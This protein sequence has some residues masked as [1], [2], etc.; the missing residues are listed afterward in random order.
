MENLKKILKR[1]ITSQDQI[2]ESLF[3][4]MFLSVSGGLQDAYTYVCRGGVFANAQTGNVVLF[5]MNLM[6][7]NLHAALRYLTPVIAFSAGIF[8]A[9]FIQTRYKYAKKIYWRQMILIAEILLLI[10]VSMLPGT[11][12]FLANMLVSFSCALQVQT[13]RTV[14][15][16]PYASTMCIGNLRSG[17]AFFSRYLRDHKREDRKHA[18]YYFGI[19]CFFTVGAGIGA[20]LTKKFGN[21][22]ILASCVLLLAGFAMMELDRE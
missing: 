15:G 16:H 13:F 10:V 6:E 19:I 18:V 7:G 21:I 12:D 5:S 22:S 2:S 14:S 4:N 3:L 17:M 20:E 8:V 11:M 1:S 9:D